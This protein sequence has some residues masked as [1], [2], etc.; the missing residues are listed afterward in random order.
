M[1]D[2]PR[3]SDHSPVVKMNEEFRDAIAFGVLLLDLFNPF[4]MLS[5]VVLFLSMHLT[6][7]CRLILS[8]AAIVLLLTVFRC[9]FQ[10]A[11]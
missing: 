3:G 8:Y 9:C 4:W 5:F 7:R 11:H 2:T 6:Q 10:G 1:Q